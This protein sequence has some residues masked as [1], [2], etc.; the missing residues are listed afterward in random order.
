MLLLDSASITKT[1]NNTHK[2]PMNNSILE[3]QLADQRDAAELRVAEL[4]SRIRDVLIDNSALVSADECIKRNCSFWEQEFLKSESRI[5]SLERE[6][7]IMD[8]DVGKCHDAIGECRHSDS[9]E[10]W[11]F[12][13]NFQKTIERIRSLESENAELRTTIEDMEEAREDRN[14][15]ARFY[16]LL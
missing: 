6:L 15:E 1:T 12:F 14:S 3:Q 8:E 16:D 5:R 9:S 10:L 11:K 4:E 2:E 13:E 7:A